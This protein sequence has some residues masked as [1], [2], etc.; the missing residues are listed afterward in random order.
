MHF[1][2]FHLAAF[3]FKGFSAI[4]CIAQMT[5]YLQCVE[6]N[7]HEVDCQMCCIIGQLPLHAI[8]DPQC[9]DNNFPIDTITSSSV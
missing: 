6:Y 9:V 3:V 5:L 4:L 2:M 7:D 1:E 8:R